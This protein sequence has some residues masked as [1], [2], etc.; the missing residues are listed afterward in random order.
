MYLLGLS[1]MDD[2][3]IWRVPESLNE[4]LALVK[5]WNTAADV[6]QPLNEMG[7]LGPIRPIV[8]RV[9][10]PTAGLRQHER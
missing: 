4:E 8:F 9:P 10:G 6:R 3:A 5:K 1:S 2:V 7:D